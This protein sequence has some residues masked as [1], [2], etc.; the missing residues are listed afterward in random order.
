EKRAR[1]D[2]RPQHSRFAVGRDGDRLRPQDE[3]D[4]ISKLHARRDLVEEDDGTQRGDAWTTI[5]RA[6]HGSPA[7]VHAADEASD[8]WRR[9]SVIEVL[10]APLLYDAAAVHHRD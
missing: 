6:N 7:Q 10:G 1:E 5:G 9:G 3:M 2:F 8:E 4:S